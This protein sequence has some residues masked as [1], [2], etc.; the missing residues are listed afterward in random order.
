MELSLRSRVLTGASTAVLAATGI[1]MAGPAQAATQPYFTYANGW[2]VDVHVRELADLDAD[3]YA[4]IVG[5]GDAGTYTAHGRGDGTFTAPVLAIAQYGTDQ[6]WAGG[7]SPRTTGDVDGDGRDDLLGFGTKGVQ[8]S[9]HRAD[10]SFT[11]PVQTVDDFGWAQGWTVE[12]HLREVADVNGDGIDD[13]VGFGDA[14]V[15][16]AY[17]RADRTFTAPALKIPDFGRNQG[18]RTDQHPRQ[19][20][21]VDGDGVDDV[22]GFGWGGTWISYGRADSTFTAPVREI[23]DFG[24]AQGWRV[25][26]HPRAVGDVNGDGRADVIGFGERGVLA[27]YSR[28]FAAGE[29]KFFPV[30]LELADFGRAQGWR[31]DR[32]PRTLADLN[33][34]GIQDV[35]GFGDPGTF[36]A[37][38]DDNVL[39]NHSLTTTEFG[40]DSGWTPARYPRLLGD[41]DGDGR[42]D[43]V[44]FGHSLLYTR[45]L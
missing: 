9:Y 27:A 26:R 36:V 28:A 15:S 1:G 8:V 24:V 16:V 17:G 31:V 35:V 30:T 7:Q 33:G 45:L 22:V 25:D 20:A 2:R 19:L 10:G 40:Y 5:F 18:W 32:H 4:D 43:V 29:P 41:L 6:G 12:R 38:G 42:D 13:V 34:D 3:P 21:D 11:D 44:G 37:Y 14:G 23:R 39:V